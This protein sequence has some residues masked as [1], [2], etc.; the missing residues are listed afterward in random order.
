MQRGWI[1]FVCLAA[2]W[3]SAAQAF[4]SPSDE[5][6][7]YNRAGTLSFTHDKAYCSSHRSLCF[8]L[9]RGYD[10]AKYETRRLR[11]GPFRAVSYPQADSVALLGYYDIGAGEP[12][13]TDAGGAIVD[14][15]SGRVLF[16]DDNRDRVL[17]EWRARGNPEPRMVVADH[18]HGFSPLP[19]RV[20]GVRVSFI[21][22]GW[23]LLMAGIVIL[24]IRASNRRLVAARARLI[25]AP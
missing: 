16:R 18:D 5:E 11:T 6:L 12:P 24:S 7:E 10:P 25:A 22:A 23:A 19:W 4:G 13:E 9:N 3:P 20:Y 21:V 15:A 2:L 14:I 1:V 17:A 8:Y